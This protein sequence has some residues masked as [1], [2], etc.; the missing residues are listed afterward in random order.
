MFS[1]V[2]SEERVPA[3]H[4]LRTLW[5]LS[6]AVLQEL[7]RL[8]DELYSSTGR[9]SIPPEQLLR[10]MLLQILY[11]IRSERLL[12]AKLEYN[13]LFRWSVGLDVDDPICDETVFSTNRKWLLTGEVAAAFFARVRA[14]AEEHGLL[15]DEHFPDDGTMVEAWAGQKSFQRKDRPDAPRNRDGRSRANFR[16]ETRRNQTHAS[17]TDRQ[18]RLYRKSHHAEAKLA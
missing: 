11:T 7:S 1:Y 15:S 14:L 12:M 4:P 16:G 5:V 3:E 18:A 2:S 9:P 8:L 6:G 10:A 17:T 13:L